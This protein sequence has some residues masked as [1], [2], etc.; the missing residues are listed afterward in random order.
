MRRG[1]AAEA[2][3]TDESLQ[4]P[5]SDAAGASSRC[6]D[7]AQAPYESSR[8][9]TAAGC[10]R[11][12]SWQ[13]SCRASGSGTPGIEVVDLDEVAEIGDA[14]RDMTGGR[15]AARGVKVQLKPEL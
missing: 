3:V 12:A 1:S 4:P 14:I 10:R 2:R 15:A 7:A 5:Q 6:K 13:V 9:T 8:C 11:T